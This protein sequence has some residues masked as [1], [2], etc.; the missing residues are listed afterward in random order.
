VSHKP[1][2][3]VAALTGADFLLW[4]VSLSANNVV[5]ALIAGLTLPPLVAACA[6]MIVLN[7]ARLVSRIRAAGMA[8]GPRHRATRRR[9]PATARPAVRHSQ[10]DPVAQTLRTARARGA[11]ATP[12]HDGAPATAA[13]G[14]SP[15]PAR[16]LAA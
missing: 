12:E 11:H 13:T 16:K 2:A 7:T 10:P 4:N 5:L 14:R 15:T 8:T 1:L 9:A 6:L 3:L